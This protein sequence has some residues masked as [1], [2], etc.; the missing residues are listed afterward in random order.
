MLA[1]SLTLFVTVTKSFTPY[2]PI[3]L[4]EKW[5]NWPVG[6]HCSHCESVTQA[7]IKAEMWGMH[8]CFRSCLGSW[9]NNS[10]NNK[11]DRSLYIMKMC[12]FV[13][14]IFVSCIS[15]TSCYQSSAPHLGDIGSLNI[16]ICTLKE[17]WRCVMGISFFHLHRPSHC[18]WQ[19]YPWI[20]VSILRGHSLPFYIAWSLWL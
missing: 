9:L 15:W 6:H 13:L 14:F 20:R 18:D 4:S 19:Y 10:T 11:K 12:R 17:N 1:V 8:L 5:G 7:H 16:F 2:S 3:V